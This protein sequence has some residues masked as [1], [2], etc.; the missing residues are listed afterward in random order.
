MNDNE[1]DYQSETNDAQQEKQLQKR[2]KAEKKEAKRVK[3]TERKDKKLE[4]H[5]QGKYYFWE[6]NNSNFTRAKILEVNL[7]FYATIVFSITLFFAAVFAVSDVQKLWKTLSFVFPAIMI[8]F[9]FF[10]RFMESIISNIR[11]QKMSLVIQRVMG[12]LYI[13]VFFTYF[14]IMI[15]MMNDGTSIDIRGWIIFNIIVSSTLIV[16][17][18][19]A[20]S[21][22]GL[23]KI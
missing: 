15:V 5:E 2:I 21:V 13:L 7:F 11:N 8:V 16:L 9:A 6:F 10:N 23:G 17:K 22:Y 14:F 12:I 19:A 1:F 4:R 3:K 18:T 20:V